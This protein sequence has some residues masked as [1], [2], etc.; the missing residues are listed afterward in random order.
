[1]VLK[2]KRVAGAVLHDPKFVTNI[3]FGGELKA[4]D[5]TLVN[6]PRPLSGLR[7]VNKGE[8]DA[9]VVD[10]SVLANMASLPFASELAV[11]HTSSTLPL[12]VVVALPG[13]V[14]YVA[15]FK[16]KMADICGSA[17]GKTVC[18]AALLESIQPATEADYKPLVCLYEGKS[19]GKK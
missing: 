5:V 9:A 3:L 6:E 8:A 12:P 14:P 2:G 16:A 15:G 13:G 7:A 10:R 1:M 4:S 11:I 18:E 17:Q 19:C